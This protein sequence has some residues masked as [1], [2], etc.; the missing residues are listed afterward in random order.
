MRQLLVLLFI[1]L[2]LLSCQKA[3]GTKDQMLEEAAVQKKDFAGVHFD[4]VYDPVCKMSLSSGIADTS[5]LNGKTYGFCRATCKFQFQSN[6][7]SFLK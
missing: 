7:D 4:L 2:A 5:L 1:G 6:P 3:D